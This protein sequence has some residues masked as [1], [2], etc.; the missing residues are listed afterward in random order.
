M[1]T[2]GI[3]IAA[4][5]T[6]CIYSFLYK[7]NILYKF[8]EH[9]LVGMAAGY[10]VAITFWQ[11]IIPNLIDPLFNPEPYKSP[12]LWLILPFVFGLMLLTRFNSQIAWLSRW[13]L[14]FIIGTSSGVALI[15]IAQGDLVNQIH[16][17]ATM[18]LDPSG[19]VIVA[20]NSLLILIG[21]IST[22]IYFFFSKEH[23]GVLGFTAKIGIWFLM[24]SFGA[25][26]GYTVMARISLLIGRMQF[27]LGDWLHLIK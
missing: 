24:V 3:W 2:L 11:V 10:G 12:D 25:S 26:F 21:V 22:L 23:K 16:A 5:L 18:S 19:R 17:T 7:D 27:L 4:F 6:L 8:A 14:S 20:I 15:G 9:L 1:D 13:P